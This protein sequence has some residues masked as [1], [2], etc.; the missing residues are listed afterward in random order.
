[1][2]KE[3]YD[4]YDQ[5]F[6]RLSDSLALSD[7]CTLCQEQGLG[8]VGRDI[9]WGNGARDARL[10]VVG[11]DSADRKPNERLWR[12]SRCTGLPL[13]NKKSGAKLR[14]MLAKADIYSRTTVFFTNTVKCN[15]GRDEPGLRLSFADLADVCLQHLRREL[16]IVR[17]KILIA[18][19]EPA[20]ERVWGFWHTRSSLPSVGLAPEVTLVGFHPFTGALN[21]AAGED[22]GHATVEVFALMHPSRVEGSR[23]DP[24]VANLRA[25]VARLS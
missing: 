13:T 10:M 9:V 2:R 21:E 5:L 15:V 22:G 8:F 20:A 17:P 23:E 25:I 7:G 3:E 19:G 6:P 16:A 18:L 14:I 4:R 12:G 11:R 24:Y 1:M